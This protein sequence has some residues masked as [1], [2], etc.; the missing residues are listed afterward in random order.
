MKS[1][2]AIR[3]SRPANVAWAAPAWARMSPAIMAMASGRRSR[4]RVAGMAGLLSDADR[5]GGPGGAP[6]AVGPQAGGLTPRSWGVVRG[7]GLPS[8]FIRD[9]AQQHT[10]GG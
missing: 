1:Q 10:A 8:G 6:R 9:K 7:R 5:P 4:R 3:P 2:N